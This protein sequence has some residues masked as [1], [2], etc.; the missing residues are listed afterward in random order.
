MLLHPQI[1][2]LHSTAVAATMPK[3]K[4]E[5]DANGNKTKVRTNHRE[6]L[7]GCLPNLLLQSP[8]LKRHLQKVKGKKGKAHAGKEGN[9]SAE[10]AE[11][12]TEQ[13]Q[14]AEGTGDTKGSVRIFGNCVF[15]VTVQ[16]EVLF[17]IK[18]YKNAEIFF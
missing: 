1:Q 3:T 18:F 12:K 2:H 10:N 14:K 8:S 15:L 7:Q 13:A 6:D 16:F 5:G 11:A 9:N 17:F 4:A